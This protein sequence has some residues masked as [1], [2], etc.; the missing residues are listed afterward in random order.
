MSHI[1]VDSARVTWLRTPTSASALPRAASACCCSTGSGCWAPARSSKCSRPPTNW[2]ARPG[3]E[4]PYEVQ[5]LPSTAAACRVRRRRASGSTVSTFAFWSRAATFSSSPRR[6]RRA[7]GGCP[8][9]AASPAG[10]A[11]CRRLRVIETI[12]EG[13]ARARGGEPR[14]PGSAADQPLWPRRRGRHPERGE[15]SKRL[16][17]SALMFIKRDLDAELARS[18]AE[19]VMPGM[20]ATWG[21]VPCRPRA[22]R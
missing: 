18:V 17:R 11:R 7:S 22:E 4:P 14:R 10:C 15:R 16:A 5:F 1:H 2:P 21:A 12:G 9:P 19:R 20:A 3:E 8:R 6:T 13:A